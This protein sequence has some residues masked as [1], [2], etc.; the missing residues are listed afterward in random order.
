MVKTM[1]KTMRKIKF[2]YLVLFLSFFIFSCQEDDD[3]PNDNNVDLE[4]IIA[5]TNSYFPMSEGSWWEYRSVLR[6][7]EESYTT[8]Y[9]GLVEIEGR[10]YNEL[11]TKGLILSAFY[12]K[13]GS[14]LYR[15]LTKN[16][17][18]SDEYLE[19]LYF[20]ENAKLGDL[21]Y[22]EEFSYQYSPARIKRE[23]TEKLDST[24]FGGKIYTDILHISQ[25]FQYKPNPSGSWFDLTYT[26]EYYAKGIGYLGM[27]GDTGNEG[28]S[29]LDYQIK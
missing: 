11:I 28:I 17:L 25:V 10:E 21:W 26:E 9:K 14:K 15:L 3:E 2:V 1:R 23:V 4:I 7:I 19:M 12:R 24:S 16:E 29:L 18:G 27:K 8:E 5:D 20:D 13:E 6:G 22:S